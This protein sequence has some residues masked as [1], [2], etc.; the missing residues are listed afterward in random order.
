MNLGLNA[1]DCEQRLS[2]RRSEMPAAISRVSGKIE[3]IVGR[4]NQ[5]GRSLPVV[6]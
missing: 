4:R 5:L 6:M 3:R 2:R 1:E